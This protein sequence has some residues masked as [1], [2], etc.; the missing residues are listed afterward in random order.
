MER[1]GESF[2]GMA[3]RNGRIVALFPEGPGP[4]ARVRAREVVDLG[5]RAVLPGLTDGHVHLLAAAVFSQATLAVADIDSS[6]LR[7]TTL[8]GVAEKLR[9]YAATAPK[10]RP[11]FCVNYVIEAVEEKRLPNRLELDGWLPDR[12]VIVLSMDG[13]SSAYSSAALSALRLTEVCPDGILS[14]SAHELNVGRVNAHLAR[15]VS[16]GMLARGIQ[17]VVNEAL[18]Q[19]IVCIDC[20][21]GFEDQESDPSLWLLARCGGILPI[22]LRLHIQYRDPVRLAPYLRFMR[23]PRIGGCFGWAMDGSISSETAAI[24]EPYLSDP[25][26]MGRLYFAA[27]EAAAMVARAASAGMQITSHAIG[28]RAIEVILSAFEKVVE[29]GNPLRHRIDHFELP[30]ADQVRRA[31][32]LG[33]ALVAQPGFTWLDEK[34]LSG[35]RRKLPPATWDSQ[36]PLATIVRAGGMIVGSSDFPTEPI[37][38]WI[39]LQGMVEYPLARERLGLYDALRTFTWNAAWAAGEEAE[40]GTLAPGKKADFIVMEEDPFALPADR[41]QQAAV[42]DTYIDGRK[43]RVMRMSTAAFMARAFLGPRK[44]I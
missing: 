39:Q 13:H 5:G 15:G 8:A 2:A 3:V 32:G 42:R 6:G 12:E 36:I 35:Y 27:E 24:A 41:I 33:L 34:F 28:A 11:L 38:P 7:R 30:T 21:E 25:A 43:A 18:R 4:E 31:V 16:V 14:G 26:S 44:K 23:R 29:P 37:S 17:D 22:D 9:A 40:R 20:V 10:A 19:G 1:E